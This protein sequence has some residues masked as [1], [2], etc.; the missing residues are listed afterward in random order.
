MALTPVET[1]LDRLLGDA[2]LLAS[3][4][5]RRVGVLAN[6]ASVTGGL[7]HAVDALIAAGVDVVRLFGPEHGIRGQ[8]QDMESVDEGSDPITG[9]PLVSL[10]GDT[11]ASLKP[12][13]ADVDGLD[14]VLLDLPDIGTR[15]YTYAATAAY[16]A[17]E[18]QRQGV[19]AWV[20]DRPNPINGVDVEGNLVDPGFESFVGALSVPN[21]HGMTLAELL[22]YQGRHGPDPYHVEV[23]AL[24]G[25]RREQWFDECRLPWVYP[26]PNMP[27]LETAIIYPGMCLIEATEASEARGT[28]RPFELFGAPWVDSHALCKSLS[29][30][31]LPGVLFRPAV[32]KPGFQKHSGAVCHGA[33]IHIT[34]RA[35]VRS[36]ELGL[37][38][39]HT[40]MRLYPDEFEWR[41]KP[42]EF[43][44][45]VPA[46]DLLCGNASV[47]AALDQ[48]A[49]LAEV[50]EAATSRD[51]G[52][53]VRRA[54]ALIY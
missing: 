34:E 1:G 4:A 11:L 28:T 30:L 44:D 17:A 42:Y 45:E 46:M 52:F 9:L 8:A 16:L 6:H 29:E 5:G 40:L 15:Y 33:Q 53:D 19:E 13:A 14:V 7:V 50:V 22:R 35:R 2:A 3:L 21:R 26:S 20:L 41:E 51:P 31:A 23:V 25:W 32:F 48:G 43:V 10:Y 54:E 12:T 38:I 39:I 18:A 37:A 36:L 24:R 47:R 49:D 27:T